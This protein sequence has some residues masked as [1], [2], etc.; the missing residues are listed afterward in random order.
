VSVCV[1]VCVCVY[2][3]MQLLADGGIW[4][5]LG[6]LLYHY[7]DSP[8]VDST[9]LSYSGMCRCSVLQCVAVRCSALQ[10]VAVRCSALQCVAARCSVLQCAL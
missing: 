5:N 4:I 9:E 6:P 7:S 3:C 10:C 1:C 2:V 8:D